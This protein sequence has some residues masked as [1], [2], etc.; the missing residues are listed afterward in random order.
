ME[1]SNWAMQNGL[2]EESE[3][4]AKDAL[5]LSITFTSL[6]VF[7]VSARLYTRGFLVKKIGSDDWTCLVSLVC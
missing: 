4:K 3:D 6:A 7:F 2:S 1:T 5:I